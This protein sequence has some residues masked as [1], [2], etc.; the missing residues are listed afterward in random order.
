MYK[1]SCLCGGVTYELRGEL[2]PIVFCHCSRC[3]KA[4][5][6]AFGTNSP[7]RKDEFHL[8]S[9]QDLLREYE[10][11]P[12]KHRVFCSHCGSPV[13]SRNKALPHLLRLRIGLLDSTVDA[14]PVAH[15]YASSHAEWEEILD[16]LPQYEGLPPQ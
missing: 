9:G 14:R 7:V 2:G 3:R 5:G 4:Q 8:L 12:G 13:F 15:I 16:S 6:S 1:G 10:S 11:S